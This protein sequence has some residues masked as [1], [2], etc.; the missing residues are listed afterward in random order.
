MTERRK[1][2]QEI[3]NAP[4]ASSIP[5]GYLF[6]SI[7]EM[8]TG[9]SEEEL[10]LI[11]DLNDP[12]F[13][14]NKQEVGR[15]IPVS[16]F[17][18]L[19]DYP[20]LRRVLEIALSCIRNKLGT[21]ANFVERHGLTYGQAIDKGF[22]DPLVVPSTITAAAELLVAVDQMDPH[23]RTLDHIAIREEMANY[24]DTINRILARG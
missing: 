14:P 21:T 9:F 1:A 8:L 5:E 10:A 20:E 4:V 12:V 2:L 23:M 16:R 24:I 15:L 19:Y 13:V 22:M 7:S 18:A 17:I 11:V 6:V 3:G